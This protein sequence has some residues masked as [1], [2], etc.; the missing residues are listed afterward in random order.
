MKYLAKAAVYS[1]IRT[2]HWTQ[3]EHIVEFFNVETWWY[4]KNPLGFKRLIV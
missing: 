3:R 4:V 2:K 1:E